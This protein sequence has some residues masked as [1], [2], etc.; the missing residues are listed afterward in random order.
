M[1][2]LPL[3]INT[4]LFIAICMLLSY[5]ALQIFKPKPRPIAA[6][7]AAEVVEPAVGQMGNFF[8]VSAAQENAPSNYQLKGVIVA[9]KEKDSAAIIVVEGKP[10]YAIGIGKELSPGVKLQEVHATHIVVSE[11]GIPKRIDLP[12]NSLESPNIIKSQ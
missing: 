1:K 12:Q 2:R 6:P 3:I 5:W 11:N 9:A 10:T 4:I 7:A 8:G